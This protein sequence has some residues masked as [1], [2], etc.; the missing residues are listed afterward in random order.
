MVLTA[1]RATERWALS[2]DKEAFR[3]NLYWVFEG[4]PHPV[5]ARRKR[6]G[7]SGMLPI[8]QRADDLLQQL[9]CRVEVM[10][11]ILT[12]YNAA[13]LSDWYASR[14]PPRRRSTQD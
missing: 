8:Q 1:S 6:E 2:R 10:I 11:A 4:V 13:A 12:K 9:S 14:L 5:G 3:G 7:P